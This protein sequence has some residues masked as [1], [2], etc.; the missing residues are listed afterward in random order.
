MLR[1][2]WIA[3]ALLASTTS[4]SAAQR[5]ATT[6]DAAEAEGAKFARSV[7]PTVVANVFA[8]AFEGT[9]E[10]KCVAA[11]AVDSIPHFLRSGEF[12]VQG[13]FRGE[14]GPR[15]NGDAKFLWTPLHNPYR[16]PSAS[17]LLI[18]GARIGHASDKLRQSVARAVYPGTRLKYS[19]AAFATLVRFPTAGQ[20]LV[21]VTA[22]KDW[23]CFLLTVAG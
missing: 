12:I 10:R 3:A 6:V 11:Q 21:V 9:A 20:W 4:A 14:W 16:Y 23:G 8:G 13:M 19:E 7:A 22:G 15:A 1:T 17:G 5:I 2:S 18:R